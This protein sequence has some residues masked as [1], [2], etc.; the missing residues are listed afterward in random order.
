MVQAAVGWQCPDCLS[1]GRKKTRQVRPMTFSRNRTGVVGST[2]PTPMVLTLIAVNVVVFVASGFGKS[3]VI[4]RFGLVPAFVHGQHQY[5]RLFDS[6]FLH[7]NFLHIA[8]NMLA[9]SSL[10][11]QSRSCS[12]VPASSR[13]TS[14]PA[15]EVESSTT[16]SPQRYP[17]WLGR[18]APSSG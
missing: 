3:S 10:A 17:R 16:S 8:G 9:S 13:S 5:Y 14:L 4:I 7:L 1:A 6:M 2:N 15:S 12:D 18:Q 11:P